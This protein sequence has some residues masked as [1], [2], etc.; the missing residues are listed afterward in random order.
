MNITDT[1]IKNPVFA[2]MLMACTVLF[3]VVALTRVGVSQYPDV[4]NPNITV[5]LSWPGAA[6][7]AIER[8]RTKSRCF[9]KS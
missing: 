6:P 3:G 8:R 5:S 7:P 9:A 4:D 2:W 1:A